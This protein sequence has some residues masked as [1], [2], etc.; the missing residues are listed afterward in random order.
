MTRKSLNL[1]LL[2]LCANVSFAA[3]DP[4]AW[5][6]TSG[7]IPAQSMYGNRYVKVY[8]FTSNLPFTM[9]TALIINKTA[10]TNEFTFSDQCS[11]HKLRSGEFCEVSVGFSPTSTGQKSASLAMRFGGNLVPLPAINTTTRNALLNTNWVGLIGVD[12]SPNHYANGSPFN[13]HDVFYVGTANGNAISN[14][15]QEMAQLQAAGFNTVRSYQTIEYPWIDIINQANALGMHV[16]YEADIPQDGGSTDI[17]TA[18]SVLNNV[19][20]AVGANVFSSTVTLVL[21]G[22]ENYNGS[23]VT[24]L[25][26]AVTSLQ[27]ALTANGVTNIPVS[28]ALVSGNLVTPGNVADMTTLINSYSAAAP[29]GFDPYPFQWGVTPPNL[30]V[31]SVTLTNSIAWDYAGAQAQSFYVSPRPIL[32]AETGWAT[33][34]TGQFA[35]YYCYIQG[36]CQPSVANAATYLTAIYEYVQTAAN[37]SGVLVFEAYDEPAKDPTNP[38]DAEN[39]YGMF[40]SNCNLKNNNLGLIPNASYV[41]ASNYGCQGYINGALLNVV[42]TQPGSTTNQPPFTVQVTQTNPTTSQSANF[43]ALI[44]NQDRTNPNL[45][46]WPQ[47]L[48]FNGATITITGQTSGASCNTTATVSGTTIT[49]GAVSCTDPGYLVTC[50]SNTCYLPWNNF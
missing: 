21:A 41:P 2:S 7:S 43:S 33:Q 27:A 16:V 45:Y 12:Y 40:D 37:N 46:P 3:T 30:A 25:T 49:F 34:G 31:S 20:T 44:P 22:H 38:T 8:R 14:T 39:F 4:I 32:M 17:T 48:I 6:A 18:V 1:L 24:Y 28:S 19:I 23:N 47:Y 50:S 36:N 29:L 15:Y 11:E 35:N 9:P 42:G 13:G 10:S 5:S 26:N